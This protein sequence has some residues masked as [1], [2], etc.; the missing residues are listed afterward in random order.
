MGLPG[1]PWAVRRNPAREMRLVSEREVDF[2]LIAAFVD[3]R[4]SGEER[5]RAVRLLS[6]SDVAFEVYSDALRARAD[7]RDESVVP[8]TAARRRRGGRGWWGIVPLAAAAVLLVAIFPRV[9]ARRDQAAFAAPATLIARPLLQQ[10]NLVRALGAGWDERD[11][12]VTRGGPSRLVDSTIAFRLGVR[13]VD[14]QVALAAGDTS[15]AG[16]LSAEIVASLEPVPF[17]N[18][19]QADYSALRSR[20]AQGEPRDTLIA[21]ATRAEVALEDF[22]Q[23]PWFDYGKWLGAGEL[24]ARA[25]SAEFFADDRT[26]RFLDA[27]VNRRELAPGDAESLRQ[28]AVLAKQGVAGEEFDTTR[29]IFR[30]LIRRHGG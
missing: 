8:I 4:L 6:E 27:A 30:T 16:R 15:R 12:S 13:A 28:L 7:L 9:Q 29:E 20:L 17:A 11:W 26:A 1:V 18:A 24:A 21:S 14:L 25:R 2:E 3:G 5:E 19:V 23:S 22:L 10:T